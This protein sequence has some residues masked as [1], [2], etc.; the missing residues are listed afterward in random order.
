MQVRQSKLRANRKAMPVVAILGPAALALN[1][2]STPPHRTLTD[3]FLG[4]M[5]RSCFVIMWSSLVRSKG[6][7]LHTI[8]SEGFARHIRIAPNKDFFPFEPWKLS[9][10]RESL[11]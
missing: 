9:S 8:S 6:L 3:C 11:S 10:L 5:K 1:L 4:A 7:G 2:I